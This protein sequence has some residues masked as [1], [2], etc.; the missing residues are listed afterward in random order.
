MILKY[1]SNSRPVCFALKAGAWSIFILAIA[2]GGACAAGGK[3]QQP[4]APVPDVSGE[5][6]FLGPQD[7]LAILEEE[8]TLKGY[9]DA[10]QNDEESDAIFSYPIIIGSRQGDH[11]EFKTGKIHEKYYRFSGTAARGSGAKRSDPD[12]LE[13][14][15]ELEIITA[16]SV[17]NTE[18]IEK[19]HV[20]L[21]SLGKDEQ[22]D[23]G[24]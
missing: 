17:T 9:V 12:Y 24:N 15:G 11:L 19:K 14:T 20:V 3:K 23:D 10:Y 8:G 2:A 6:H 21:K 16:N 4:A 18:N 22:T 5:Y 7:K 1:R 13:L